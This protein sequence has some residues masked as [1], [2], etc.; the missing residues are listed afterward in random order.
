M[1]HIKS[2]E[3]YNKPKILLGDFVNIG[4]AKNYKYYRVVGVNPKIKIQ[5]VL[6]KNGEEELGDI[7][8]L[9]DED[10]K[11]IKNS[12]T[13]FNNTYPE[14]ESPYWHLDKLSK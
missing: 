4:S 12:P 2:F 6:N 9:S 13:F 3:S 8:I 7:I 11:N 5:E 1:K 14:N 10:V